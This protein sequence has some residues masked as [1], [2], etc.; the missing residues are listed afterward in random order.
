MSMPSPNAD[1][2]IQREDSKCK[3]DEEG[4]SAGGGFRRVECAAAPET[5][6]AYTARSTG[7]DRADAPR[8][9]DAAAIVG[10]ELRNPVSAIGIGIE[11]LKSGE[12]QPN[13]ARQTLDMMQRQVG[14]IARLLDDLIDGACL[15]DSKLEIE[16]E[17]VD[18]TQVGLGALDMMGPLIED[19][20]HELT[21]ALPDAGTVWVWG[22]SARLIEAVVNLLSNAV[23]YTPSGGR[24]ALEISAD[25][26]TAV[27]TVRDSGMG[28]AADFMPRVFE[29]LTQGRR[30]LDGADPG[31]GIGLPLVRNF[32]QLHGGEVTVFSAGEGKGSEFQVRLPRSSSRKAPRR[33]GR[34]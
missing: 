6:A 8:S 18:L 28:I 19:R 27:I 23:K 10:H 11:L 29:P 17:R 33:A 14:Q 30:S 34:R 3:R 9:I 2:S 7:A 22:D 32:A 13:R 1:R 20:G 31:Q 24:I 5:G 26:E 4:R 16:R 12:L 25:A 15:T 21:V